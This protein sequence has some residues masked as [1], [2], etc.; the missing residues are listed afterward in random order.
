MKRNDLVRRSDVLALVKVYQR[1]FGGTDLLVPFRAVA[2][3]D[4]KSIPSITDEELM[5]EAKKICKMPLGHGMTLQSAS[6]LVLSLFGIH[7]GLLPGVGS[8]IEN[9]EGEHDS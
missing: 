3:E 7:K 1:S 6:D 4:L 9:V 8:A 2:E 5:A